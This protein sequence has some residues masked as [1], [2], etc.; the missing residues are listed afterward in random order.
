MDFMRSSGDDMACSS[1]NT[2]GSGRAIRFFVIL[3]F[4][5]AI[6]Y[7]VF[8]FILVVW[9]VPIK[10][11]VYPSILH[12]LCQRIPFLAF[13]IGVI[14]LLK[15][16]RKQPPIK[17]KGIAISAI[18][19]SGISIILEILNFLAIAAKLKAFPPGGP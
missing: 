7:W 1:S 12:F 15:I 10:N 8:T 9:G 18:V 11:T 17:G 13:A 3:S 5:L 14:T 2:S 16:K 4:C 6:L 19:I